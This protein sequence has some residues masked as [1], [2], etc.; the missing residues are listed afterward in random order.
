[1][2]RGVPAEVW[3]ASLGTALD[4]DEALARRI[5][6][7]SLLWAESPQTRES[8]LTRTEAWLW[9]GCF[10]RLPHL[11]FRRDIQVVRAML[12]AAGHRLVFQRGWQG[13]GYSIEGQ[14]QYSPHCQKMVAGAAAEMLRHCMEEHGLTQSDLPEAGSQG[15]VS[16]VLN[17]KRE[18]NVRQIR[19]LARR[20][21]VAPAVFI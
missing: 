6:L 15:V 5:A 2:S 19:A 20:F 12:A 14:P 7:L 21:Q 4:R 8:L 16:E 9:P 11:T 13:G 3:A 1:M 10:G 17:G 18:L